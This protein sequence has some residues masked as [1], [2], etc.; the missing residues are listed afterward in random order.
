MLQTT[1]LEKKMG[2]NKLAQIGP[3]DPVSR[4]DAGFDRMFDEFW[5]RPFSTVWGR[6]HLWPSHALATQ[7]PYLD[8][9]EDKDT[10]LVKA[11]VPGLSKDDL[12]VIVAGSTLTIRG[13]KKKEEKLEHGDYLYS[14]RL[15]GNF[16]RSIELPTEVKTDKVEA[17][18]KNGVLEVRLPKIEDAKHRPT[19]IR[20]N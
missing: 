12:E 5:R 1:Q 6:E 19:N 13:E 20:I 15:F 10:L 17:S 14:E 4:L 16:R 3:F 7:M 11:E 8:V 2:A 18:F 9:I